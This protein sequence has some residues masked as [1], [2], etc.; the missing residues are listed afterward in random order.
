V[1][2][3]VIANPGPASEIV[4]A[5][6]PILTSD[7]NVLGVELRYRPV[8]SDGRPV[9]PDRATATVLATALGEIGLDVLA[10]S[11][12]AFIGVTREFLVDERTPPL[13]AG[14]FVLQLTTPETVDAALTCALQTLVN[15]GFLLALDGFVLRPDLEPLLE[16]VTYVKLDVGTLAPAVL[17]EQVRELRTRNV[18]VIA[19]QVE[20]KALFDASRKLGIEAFQGSFFARPDL[21]RRDR[22]PSLSIGSLR[23]LI[24][25]DEDTFEALE[26]LISC[27]VGLSHKLLRLANSA[28]VG[29]RTPVRSIRHALTLLGAGPV[30]RWVMVLVLADGSS[31]FDELLLTALIRARMCELIARNDPDADPDRAFTAGLFSVADSLLG[32]PLADLVRALPFDERLVAALLEH[33]GPEGEVL[34]ATLSY[35][36]GYFDAAAELDRDLRKLAR[37]YYDALEWA[38]EFT[39]LM[40]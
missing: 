20:S 18:T 2:L 26:D 28:Y 19:T 7:L 23:A 9:D 1:S 15:E 22:T 10:G 29:A 12:P 13:P 5:R 17:A 35:E 16:L 31:E 8:G 36:Q 11:A 6:Q 4:L 14:P 3:P 39:L 33:D 25:T 38:Y 34:D 32:E 27:D 40:R 37:A 24:A 21:V 30:K